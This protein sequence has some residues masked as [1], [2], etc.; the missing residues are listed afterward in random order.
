M[1]YFFTFITVVLGWVVIALLMNQVDDDQHFTMYMLALV[2]TV[3]LFG[4]GFR[5]H[6]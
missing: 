4:I 6:G 1:R 2:N 3:V 5:K